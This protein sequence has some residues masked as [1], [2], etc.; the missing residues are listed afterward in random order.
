MTTVDYTTTPGSTTITDPKDNVEVQTHANG[1]LVTH[2]E[3]F[4][5]PAAGTWTLNTTRPPSGSAR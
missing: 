3:R 4:G 1:L 5:T 2:T